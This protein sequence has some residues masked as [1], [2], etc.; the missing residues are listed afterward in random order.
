MVS[1]PLSLRPVWAHPACRIGLLLLLDDEG[2]DEEDAGKDLQSHE[3]HENQYG[4]GPLLP[5]RG[6]ADND[7]QQ[8]PQIEGQE[9]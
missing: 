2:S 4:E 7:L 3:G 6:D 5:S 9:K 1:S 8:R